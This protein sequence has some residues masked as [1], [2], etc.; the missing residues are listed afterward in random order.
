MGNWSVSSY[1][2]APQVWSLCAIFKTQCKNKYPLYIIKNNANLRDLIAATS[3]I[4][5]FWPTWPWNWTTLKN[6]R[7]PLLCHLKEPLKLGRFF[8]VWPLSL[9]WSWFCMLIMM[10]SSNGNIFRVT[11][12]LCGNSP[13][14]GNSPHKGQWR[15]ALM[16]PLICVWI[17]GWVNNSE[18][19]DL[20]RN[21]G[22]Y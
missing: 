3:L 4:I 6:N 22:H 12:P 9:S 7:A 10:T 21:R 2:K 8:S 13:V 5:L 19:G 16:F 17:N 18:A 1:N 20:R 14:P 15:G 11:G